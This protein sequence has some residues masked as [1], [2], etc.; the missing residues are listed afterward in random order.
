MAC[1][2]KN[3][4][5]G[6]VISARIRLARNLSDMPFPRRMTPQMFIDLKERVSNAIKALPSDLALKFIEMN[7]VPETEINA[8]V[9]RHVISPDFAKNYKDRA[10]ALSADESVSI[11]IG[12][13]DHIRI[14]VISEGASLDEAYD[15]AN[16]I[17]TALN[18]S[19]H[20]AFDDRLGYLTECPTNIGT[21]LR[22]SL[23]LH[24][25]VCESRGEINMVADAAG[26]IGLTVRGMYG[27]GSKSSASLYQISNQIT[28]GISE[29]NAIENLKIIASQI[30]EREKQCRNTIEKI[31]IEDTVFRS[32]GILKYARLLSTDEFM[33]HISMIKLGID[34]GIIEGRNINPVEL[35]ISAQPYMLMKNCVAQTPGERDEARAKM[36]RELL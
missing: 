23:M 2:Y 10:I 32:L 9:E 30:E 29:K 17:D 28:L 33:K 27:E 7:N 12:E 18:E 13:E 19:L 15:I 34:E 26:K 31:N 20:F 3:N 35:L 24:L 8:M 22:A 14:Q 6:I 21:G 25:P 16:S 1:W 11:M 5:G 4:N 36:I